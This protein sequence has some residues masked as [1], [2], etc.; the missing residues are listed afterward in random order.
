M[1]RKNRPRAA[2]RTV[3][4][5]EAARRRSAPG[6]R[7]V[8]DRA[9]QR[10]RAREAELARVVRLAEVHEAAA[11]AERIEETPLTTILAELVQNAVALVRTLVGAP[12]RVLA[13]LRS[14]RYAPAG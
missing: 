1:A 6:R 14:P 3:R 7:F 5:R 10:A 13:A 11:R 2:K 12:F 4:Q 8:G 9:E